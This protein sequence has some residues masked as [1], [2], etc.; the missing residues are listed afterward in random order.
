M[1]KNV[2]ETASSDPTATDQN[3]AQVIPAHDPRKAHRKNAT[4]VCG[5]TVTA[6][7]KGGICGPNMGENV[8]QRPIQ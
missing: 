4:V 1:P 7:A 5:G 8:I 6:G 3:D 2:A